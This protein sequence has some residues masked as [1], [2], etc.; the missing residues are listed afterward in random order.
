MPQSLGRQNT[1]AATPW[2]SAGAS[3]EGTH[4]LI[5]QYN[6]AV[7]QTVTVPSDGLYTVAFSM[8][9]RKGY[10]DNQI[11]VSLDGMPL[12]SFLNR[13]VEFSPDHRQRPLWL[14][15]QPHSDPRREGAGATAPHDRRGL[16][17]DAS[18]ATPAARFPAL[19][20]EGGHRASVVLDHS[21]TNP[22]HV[23]PQ[24]AAPP[25][26]QRLP[27]SAISPAR[28]P[29]SPHPATSFPGPA[30]ACEHAARWPRHAPAAGGSASS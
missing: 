5:M 12:A 6:S 10:A 13:S 27:P 28:R 3:P 24:R 23:R 16:F 1:V 22:C 15:A 20:P 18:S 7:S 29:S 25:A 4:M 11:Y 14:A 21:G 8:L 26:L 2:N 17:L 19:A 9:L 30:R